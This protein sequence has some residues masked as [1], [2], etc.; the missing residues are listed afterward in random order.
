MPKAKKVTSVPP[1]KLRLYEKLVSSTPGIA[2]K[3]LG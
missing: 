2:S 1:D 3:S